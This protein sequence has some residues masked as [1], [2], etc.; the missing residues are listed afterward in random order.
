MDYKEY[1]KLY[2]KLL[3]DKGLYDVENE[4]GEKEKT[5]KQI[6]EFLGKYPTLLP[7]D[8][9][10]ATPIYK[11]SLMEV[12]RRTLQVAIDII[13][14][15]SDIISQKNYVSQSTFRRRVFEAF[16]KP[17]RRLYVGIWLILFSFVLYFIDSA[18]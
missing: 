4:I 1:Q 16:T 11:L 17:E 6:N 5:L 15:I 13:H 3:T 12:Y 8:K 18:A 14:D 7:K 2:E 10:P 9:N